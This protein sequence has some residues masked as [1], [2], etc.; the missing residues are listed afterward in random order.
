[1]PTI[2]SVVISLLG[3]IFIQRLLELR[4]I[5]RNV[6][7]I[8]G[9][10]YIFSVTSIPGQ[11]MDRSLPPIPYLNAGTSWMHR[12]KYQDFASAG[13]DFITL[14]TAFPRPE[15][16]IFLADADII[17]EVTTSRARFPKNLQLYDVIA[18]FGPNILLQKDMNGRGF[19]RQ[20]SW[21]SDLVVPPGHQMTFKDAIHILSSNLIMKILLPDWAQGATAHIRKVHL[22]FTELR[23][24][25]LEM[26]NDRRN[27][28]MKEE[29]YDLFS[30]LL[31]AAQEEPESG[32]AI[33]DQELMALYPDEQEPLYQHIKGVLSSLNRMPVHQNSD[34]NDGFI[35]VQR[36]IRDS[37]AVPPGDQYPQ[38]GAEDTTDNGV[39]ARAGIHYNP[40]YW[41]DPHKFK[42]ERFL[43]DWP[44]DAFLPFSQGRRFSEIEGI[45]IITMLV[46]RY[47][48]EIKEEPEFAGETFEERYAR[49]TAFKQ[50]LTLV[51]DR[52][53]LV[54]RRRE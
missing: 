32:P 9:L 53:P 12:R 8:P 25:M 28:D 5:A 31:D 24:Y 2:L 35:D 11:L 49:V 48:I 40:R 18:V 34:Q 26:V 54:L 21:T 15:C 7:N 29:R 14:I 23:Q 52:V 42:P 38:D 46:S 10:R 17:K 51:P 50:A 45:A 1:M 4:R 37:E 16:T 3:L 30:G 47:K 39:S 44:K 33:S 6:G 22:A 43:G 13:Q 36:F 27:G 19:G 20:V 41:K